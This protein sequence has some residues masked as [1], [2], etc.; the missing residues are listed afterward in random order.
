ML[1]VG[2]LLNYALISLSVLLLRY[3]KLEKL[4]L[5]LE[6]QNLLNSQQS[7]IPQSDYS[8]NLQ[9]SKCLNLNRFYSNNLNTNKSSF[10][11]CTNNCPFLNNNQQSVH[12]SGLQLIVAL[13]TSFYYRQYY[14]QTFNK[15]KKSW[16]DCH[17]QSKICSFSSNSYNQIRST[18]QVPNTDKEFNHLNENIIYQRDLPS[19]KINSDENKPQLTSCYIDKN[20]ASSLEFDFNLNYLNKLPTIQTEIKVKYILF[21]IIF[22]MISMGL[23]TSRN[24]QLLW[25]ISFLGLKPVYWPIELISCLLSLGIIYQL[26]R[27]SKQPMHQR[28][29]EKN[30]LPC[31]PLLPVCG[32]WMHLHLALCLS[33]SAWLTFIIWSLIG[34]FNLKYIH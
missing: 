21:T 23:C 7:L 24:E 27:L 19:L 9:C 1:G 29:N 8:L 26:I 5:D 2:V 14:K 11:V 32:I 25:L 15:F 31:V 13:P 12:N 20:Y 10:V 28:K 34:I 4:P 30:A 3:D 6:R 33:I 17:L 16:S 18:M 22:L